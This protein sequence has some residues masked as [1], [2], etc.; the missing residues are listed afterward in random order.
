VPVV[1]TITILDGGSGY[2]IGDSFFIKSLS[3]DVVGKVIVDEI[4]NSTINGINILD[5][6]IGYSVGDRFVFD[7]SE[8]TFGAGTV[9]NTLSGVITKVRIDQAKLFSSELPKIRFLNGNNTAN[10]LPFGSSIG[11]I[12]RFNIV[13]RGFSV[14]I[15]SYIDFPSV[16]LPE[17]KATTQINLNTLYRTPFYFRTERGTL[18]SFF[19]LQDNIY[20]QDFSYVIQSNMTLTKQMTDLYKTLIH[21]CLESKNKPNPAG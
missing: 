11:S 8:G 1:S 4:E 10:L 19:R 9:T 3:G 12:K 16:N 7:Y 2:S 6:G 18:S 15:G 5:G 14:P 21:P 13:N 17:R 20:W